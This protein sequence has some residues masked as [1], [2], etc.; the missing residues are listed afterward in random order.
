MATND[1]RRE[2]AAK[3][4]GLYPDDVLP[5]FAQVRKDIYEAI[6]CGWGQERQGQ[7]LHKRLADLIEPEPERTCRNTE[8]VLLG[9]FS[10]SECGLSLDLC[11]DGCCSDSTMMFFKGYSIFRTLDMPN[12]CPNCGAKVVE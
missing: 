9:L 6:G 3:L 5:P 10:C 7:K 4:R 12:Y 11:G 2:V 8:G 1:E